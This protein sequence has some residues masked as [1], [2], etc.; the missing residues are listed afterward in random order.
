[1]KWIGFGCGD[2][3]MQKAWVGHLRDVFI[4]HPC[5]P[6]TRVLTLESKKS[7]R[8]H[9]ARYGPPSSRLTYLD[10]LHEHT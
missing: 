1:M 5:R 8:P 9:V 3:N 6:R 7:V 10:L 4:P 2:N